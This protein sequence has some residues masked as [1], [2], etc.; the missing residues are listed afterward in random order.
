MASYNHE[1]YISQAIRSVLAQ[2]DADVELVIVDDGSTDRTPDIAAKFA[3]KDSRITFLQQENQGVVAA[4]NRALEASTGFHISLLDS[5]DVIPSYRSKIVREI[6]H[7]NDPVLI[8][9]DAQL[10]DE[11]NQKGAS[12]FSLY[13]PVDGDFAESLFLNYCFTP[14]QGVTI[15]RKALDQTGPFWGPGPNMDYLKWIE[16]GMLGDVVRVRKT[17]SYYRVHAGNESRP[18]LEKRIRQYENLKAALEQLCKEH[19]EFSA[20]LGTKNIHKRLAECHFMAGFYSIRDGDKQ[21]AASQFAKAMKLNP[22]LINQAALFS[23]AFP[24]SILTPS[25]A[26]AIARWKLGAYE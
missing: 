15:S 7:T 14:A 18:Q 13:P 6:A 16:V 12:F 4:R 11:N 23:A 24:F 21:L 20:Q 25:L 19:P 17:M 3:R 22:S 10:I 2:T 9:G 1:A 8:Y 26:K 5:D